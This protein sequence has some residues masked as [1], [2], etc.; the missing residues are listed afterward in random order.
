MSVLAEKIRG[1]TKSNKPLSER[2]LPLRTDKQRAA[3]ERGA[4]IRQVKKNERT[5]RRQADELDLANAAAE[6][7]FA[8]RSGYSCPQYRG[9][10]DAGEAGEP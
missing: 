3:D 9:L 2:R 4:L 1:M 7:L 6:F 10:A 5:H 8:L